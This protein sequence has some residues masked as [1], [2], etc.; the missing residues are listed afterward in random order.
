MEVETNKFMDSW[1][2]LEGII[3]GFPLKSE[4]KMI[5]LSCY[6]SREFKI[7]FGPLKKLMQIQ[8]ARI[9]FADC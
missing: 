3:I 9:L 7:K 2:L 4:V 8:I 1:E 6:K 5:W